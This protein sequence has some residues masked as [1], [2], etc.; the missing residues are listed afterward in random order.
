MWQ[1]TR[2]HN[3]WLAPFLPTELLGL[4]RKKWARKKSISPQDQLYECATG[5]QS[6]KCSRSI[7]LSCPLCFLGVL[8]FV[9]CM[10]LLPT[11]ED[12]TLGL[13]FKCALALSWP[14]S[15]LP[16]SSFVAREGNVKIPT[17]TSVLCSSS[18]CITSRSPSL[19]MS[20]MTIDLNFEN[21]VQTI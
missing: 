8:G 21:D 6:F 11:F 1:L 3:Q 14:S 15:S 10:M 12:Y 17:Q 20:I 5:F 16:S 4:I 18:V 7:L 13:G 19:D 2:S 9:G